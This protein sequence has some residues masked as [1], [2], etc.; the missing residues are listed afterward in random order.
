M[1]FF[2]FYNSLILS[3]LEI[4]IN[5]NIFIL[6]KYKYININIFSN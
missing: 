4:Y 5:I 3:V 1:S 2:M 6:I